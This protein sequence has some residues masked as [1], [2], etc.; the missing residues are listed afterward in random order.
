MFGGN[1]KAARDDLRDAESNWEDDIE[2]DM[3]FHIF[4]KDGSYIFAC[5]D[6]EVGHIPKRGIKNI[7][8]MGHSS[9]YDFNNDDLPTINPL[10]AI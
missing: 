1:R 3:A 2:V 5:D 7:V 6:N 9:C 8:V 10:E 4:Y